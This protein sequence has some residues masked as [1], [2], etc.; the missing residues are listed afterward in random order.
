[1]P[2]T[3]FSAALMPPAWPPSRARSSTMPA[4]LAPS[5]PCPPF[6]FFE[7]RCLFAWASCGASGS[8]NE[9]PLTI[10]LQKVY[11]SYWTRRRFNLWNLRKSSQKVLASWSKIS[12]ESDGST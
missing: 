11:R 5:P 10:E 8:T 3:A 4:S 6:M 1:M 9:K 7:I 2:T 12:K